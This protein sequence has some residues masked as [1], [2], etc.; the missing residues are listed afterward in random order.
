MSQKSGPSQTAELRQAYMKLLLEKVE[1]DGK[2]IRLVGS[3]ELLARYVET[4][5]AFTAPAVLTYAQEW[6]AVVDVG[7]NLWIACN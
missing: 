3:K 5:G 2:N 6:R 4:G 1:L 7:E